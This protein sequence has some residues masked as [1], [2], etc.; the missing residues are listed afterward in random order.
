MNISE[1]AK[2]RGGVSVDTISELSSASGVTIDSVLLKDG[3]VSTLASGTV[4]TTYL[5]AKDTQG[6][7]IK[8]AT[9]TSVMTITDAGAVTASGVKTHTLGS[10]AAGRTY[11]S[12][13]SASGASS[14]AGIRFVYGGAVSGYVGTWAANEGISGTATGDM[15]INSISN[16]HFSTGGGAVNHGSCVAGAWT[17]GPASGLAA[18]HVIQNQAVTANVALEIIKTA[19]AGGTLNSYFTTF[20]HTATEEGY[21]IHDSSGNMNFA[22]ASDARLKDNIREITGLDKCLALH[23][24]MFDWKDKTGTDNLGFIAQEVE[25]V[26]P[27]S[28]LVA[29][30]GDTK[31]LSLQ[32]E[33]IPVLVKAIQE[34]QAMIEALTA[35]L[36]ALEAK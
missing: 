29:P 20:K 35:R 11:C 10:N 25:T 13:E 32:S 5:Q 27:K 26:L 21:I 36:A 2:F 17:L 9:G 18:A 12:I 30:D 24:V 34:Q 22:N 1:L 3:N 8:N 7:E 28:V 4:T 6:I 15:I 16:I 31:I 23:P 33:I 14:S 19:V